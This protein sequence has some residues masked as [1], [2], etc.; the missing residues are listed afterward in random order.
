MNILTVSKSKT[1]LLLFGVGLVLAACSPSAQP[2]A[3]TNTQ[4][5]AILE[6][7]GSGLSTSTYSAFL[8]AGVARVRTAARGSLTVDIDGPN[9]FSSQV[10]HVGSEAES[11]NEIQI[12]A[13]GTYQI[14]IDYVGSGS[15]KVTI[16]MTGNASA[17]PAAPSATPE[18]IA[19]TEAVVPTD[20]PAAI[21]ANTQEPVLPTNTVAAVLEFH[22][23]GISVNRY[24][25]SLPAGTVRFHVTAAAPLTVDI[26]G[27]GSFHY[28]VKHVGNTE[29][30]MTEVQIP[31][32]GLYD[33]VIDHAGSGSWTVTIETSGAASAGPD[34]TA[35]LQPTTAASGPLTYKGSGTSVYEYQAVLR[36]GNARFQA[37]TS[38][39]L[40][41]DI[42]GPN[43]FYYQVEHPGITSQTVTNVEIPVDGTYVLWINHVGSGSWS[44]TVTQ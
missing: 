27:P 22:G 19:A 18:I 32:A 16:D 14:T 7:G 33:L 5:P 21:P 37:N 39:V 1:V 11:M 10:L 26:T 29:K 12:P 38:G 20:T 31:A 6:Y 24:Q 41:V 28:Q 9:G 23:S 30:T 13:D 2:A 34:A 4:A 36:A 42:T 3:P 40:T 15:W 35:T 43:G 8:K 44:V 17:L 25:A